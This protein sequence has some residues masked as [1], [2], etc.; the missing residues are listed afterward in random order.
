MKNSRS[1]KNLKLMILASLFAAMTTVLTFYIKIPM[2]NGYLHLGD[3]MIYLAA[4]LLPSP[5]AMISAGIG[6]MLADA[7]GG[8]TIY[9]LPTFIIKALLVLP[10]SRKNA[11]ILTKRNF[12]ALIIASLIT[13]IG[14]YVAEV[15]LVSI[16]ATNG[17]SHFFVYIFSSVAWVSAIY[18]IPGN[19]M[20]AVGSAI[21]FVFLAIA[22]DKIKIKDKI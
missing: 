21:V 12:L 4:V 9:M 22:L 8:Y 2:H 6:G 1:Q 19:I 13:I 7:I 5:F 20:Q 11:K 3:S 15:I 10:F 14:Y 16:S 18:C 17:F